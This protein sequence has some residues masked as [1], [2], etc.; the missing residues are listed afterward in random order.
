MFG[1]RLVLGPNCYAA[2][3]GGDVKVFS[4]IVDGHRADLSVSPDYVYIDGRGRFASFD[5]GGSDG[6][7]LRLA[8]TSVVDKPLADGEEDVLLLRGATVAEL[9]YAATKVVAMDLEGRSFKTLEPEIRNGRTVLR[10]IDGAASFRI[11]R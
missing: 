7:L 6:V 11:S 4:G 10:P 3:S 1:E 8:Y 2:R 5:E 9:P